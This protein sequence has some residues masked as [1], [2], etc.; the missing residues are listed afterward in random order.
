[1]TGAIA[2]VVC[3]ILFVIQLIKGALWREPGAIGR[4]VTSRKAAARQRSR[5]VADIGPTGGVIHA[6]ER[7]VLW[8]AC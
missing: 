6:T 3:L 5:A 7:R 8:N 2:V 1:M 4:A